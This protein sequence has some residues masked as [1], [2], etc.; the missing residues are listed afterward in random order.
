MVERLP[1]IALAK[2]RLAPSWANLFRPADWFLPWMAISICFRE[3]L[4]LLP[5]VLASV[6]AGALR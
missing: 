2:D 3:L 5:T 4:C 1:T 6:S